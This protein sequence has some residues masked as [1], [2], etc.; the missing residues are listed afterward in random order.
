[1]KIIFPKKNHKDIV[2]LYFLCFILAKVSG[3]GGDRRSFIK[4]RE[5]HRDI[6]GPSNNK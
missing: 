4:I 3:L 6:K 1:M 2:D 5:R